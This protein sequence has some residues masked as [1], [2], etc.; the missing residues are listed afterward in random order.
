M[1]LH[2]S[3]DKVLVK[4]ALRTRAELRVGLALG[5]FGDELDSA[6]FRLSTTGVGRAGNSGKRCQIAI[7]LKPLKPKHVRAEHTDASLSVAVDRAA[8][9]AVRLIDRALDRARKDAALIAR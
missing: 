5:R 4:E 6:T 9:K 7:G 2:F 3:G 1:K 8:D